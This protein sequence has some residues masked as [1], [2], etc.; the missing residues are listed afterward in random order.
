MHE[1]QKMA[2]N[3][4]DTQAVQVVRIAL[5]AAGGPAPVDRPCTQDTDAHD[6]YGSATDIWALGILAYELMVGGPPFEA[7]SK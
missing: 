4:S 5:R 7:D 6:S 3:G 1:W 2:K